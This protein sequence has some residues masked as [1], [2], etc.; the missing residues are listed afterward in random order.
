MKIFVDIGH[1]AHVH[2]FKNLIK[3]LQLKGHI[4]FISARD[5]GMVKE[6][7]EAE[8]LTF[9]NRGK[10]RNS[11]LG[12][13]LYMFIA[14][15]LLLKKALKFKPDLFLSFGSP[16]AAQ[17]S[18]LLRVPSITM[19]DT[20]HATF[21]H[22]FYKPF[23]TVLL[24]PYCFNRDFGNK[25][26]RF[27]SYMELS[28]LHPN[29][30]V[31]PK[32]IKSKLGLSEKD[33]FCILRFVSWSAN[34]DIGLSGFSL[35]EK[36]RMVKELSRFCRVFISSEKELPEDLMEYRFPLSPDQIHFALSECNLL[37][38]ESSTM[39]SE[40]AV[41]G[42]NAIFLDGVGRGYTDEQDA[43]Y[44]LV[45]NFRN[46]KGVLEKAIEL[47]KDNKSQVNAKKNCIKLIK[48]KIDVTA[49]LVWFIE[50]YPESAKIMKENPDYQDRFR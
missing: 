16:Y 14:D 22:L 32:G 49:F 43:K 28:Y 24:N 23:S 8:N 12:K 17:V 11:I 48:D 37:V 50:N 29:Y 42:T 46:S 27:D 13:I 15:S 44:K 39:A 34:H 35:D 40:S 18:A 36:R 47:L 45:Y 21:G 7:L 4:F 19:D 31:P 26:I 30:F 9:Y 6:L 1:P 2:Y 33:Q 20:E 25:Q 10:G 5:R 3:F 41:L 38:G